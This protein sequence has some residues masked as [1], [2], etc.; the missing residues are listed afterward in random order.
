MSLDLL[1]PMFDTGGRHFYVNKVAE[2]QD[3][4][5]VIPLRWVT[6]KGNVY[7]DAMLVE[8]RPQVCHLL[9]GTISV[10]SN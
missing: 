7:A 4:R 9:R 8:T 1:S 3:G 10:Q 6:F 5:K 2:L